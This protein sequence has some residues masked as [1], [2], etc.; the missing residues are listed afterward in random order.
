MTRTALL[1]AVLLA[2]SNL[3]ACSKCD[4]PTYQSQACRE[5]PAAR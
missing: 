2:A 4:V 1:I 5:S 3:A